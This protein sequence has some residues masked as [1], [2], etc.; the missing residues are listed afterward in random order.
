MLQT[1]KKWLKTIANPTAVPTQ[2]ELFK[3]ASLMH[4]SIRVVDHTDRQFRALY[5]D[6]KL[7]SRSYWSDQFPVSNIYHYFFLCAAHLAKKP[8]RVLI[9]GGGGFCLPTYL[10]HFDPQ[11]KVETVEIDPYLYPIA[12]LYF[13]APAPSDLYRVFHTDVLQFEETS[14]RDRYDVLFIDIGWRERDRKADQAIK[15]TLEAAFPKV[16]PKGFFMA[17]FM[18]TYHGNGQKWM[19]KWIKIISQKWP[20]VTVFLDFPDQPETFQDIIVI[21]STQPLNPPK[22]QQFL[23]QSPLL[24]HRFDELEGLYRDHVVTGHRI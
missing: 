19:N 20:Y 22:Y 6:D 10:A 21:A 11:M 15:A 2:V 24:Y 16:T 7:A 17:N 23:E 13:G 8:W 18:S 12:Q 1:I 4:P 5:F 14:S 3:Y 9:A